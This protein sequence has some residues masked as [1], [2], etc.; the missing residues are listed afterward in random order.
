MRFGKLTHL[1]RRIEGG[2]ELDQMPKPRAQSAATR[3]RL[4]LTSVASEIFQLVFAAR[5]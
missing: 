2:N 1:P 4:G 3:R 5:A